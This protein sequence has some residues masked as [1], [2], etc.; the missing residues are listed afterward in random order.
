MPVPFVFKVFSAA[1]FLVSTWSFAT[2][3]WSFEPRDFLKQFCTECHQAAHAEAGLDLTSL[4]LE[5]EQPQTFVRWE[6]IYDRVLAHEMPPNDAP[7]PKASDSQ[8]FAA[9]LA[10]QLSAAHRASKSSG[11]RRLNR[12]EYHNTLND[13]FGTQVDLLHLLPEDGRAHEFDNIGQALSLSPMQMER[14]MEGFNQVCSAAI[15]VSTEPPARKLTRA[16]YADTRGVE[17]WLDKIWLKLADGAVV[18]F[19]DYGYPSGMLREANVAKDGWYTVRVT[20]YA[21]QS[22][23]PITFALGAT[24]FA[25]GVPEPTFGYFELAPGASQTVETQA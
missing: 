8:S 24:T 2:N 14:Y 5:L 4:T 21:Y 18:L 12:I 19:K 16:S 6:R 17:Q 7:Q 23:R 1:A 11:L 15:A 10:K 13:L 22:D 20:G 9:N 25:R 3:L